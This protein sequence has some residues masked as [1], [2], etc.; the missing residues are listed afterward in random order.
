MASPNTFQANAPQKFQNIQGNI[1]Q[2]IG[3]VQNQVQNMANRHFGSSSPYAHLTPQLS[4][5][6][7]QGGTKPRNVHGST[8]GFQTVDPTTQEGEVGPQALG[9]YAPDINDSQFQNENF[10]KKGLRGS[11]QPLGY[12][13]FGGMGSMMGMG[14][15][16]GMGGMDPMMAMFLQMLMGGGGMGGP[17][18]G[19]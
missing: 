7:G 2:G 13:N 8:D 15:M 11:N 1:T 4:H 17:Q 19:R 5:P 14:M 6:Y 12:G 10:G 3:K 16:G 18:V 9:T